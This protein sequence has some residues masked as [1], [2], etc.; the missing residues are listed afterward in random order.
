MRLDVQFRVRTWNFVWRITICWMSLLKDLECFKRLYYSVSRREFKFVLT[1][2]TPFLLALWYPGLFVSRAHA[3]LYVKP[4]VTCARETLKMIFGSPIY[5]SS[6]V[7]II[8]GLCFCMKKTTTN[9][10][11]SLYLVHTMQST[12]LKGQCHIYFFVSK[13]SLYLAC[14]LGAQ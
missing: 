2:D 8:Y 5:N 3:K 11:K 7:G 1:F 9:I 13:C 14:I 4:H 10:K 12:C 6:T